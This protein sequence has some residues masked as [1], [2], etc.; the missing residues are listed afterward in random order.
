MLIIQKS[1]DSNTLDW[2]GVLLSQNGLSHQTQDINEINIGYT[3]TI[4]WN[5]G[6]YT[7]CEK[8]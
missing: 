4:V 6:W 8:E 2:I 5:D 1:N 7:T 3:Y